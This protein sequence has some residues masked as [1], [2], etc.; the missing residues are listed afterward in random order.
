MGNSF[1]RRCRPWS[2]PYGASYRP[3]V[4][5]STVDSTPGSSILLGGTQTTLEYALW[6]PGVGGLYSRVVNSPGGNQTTLEYA[7]WC[8]GSGSTLLQG[9]QLS[10]EIPNDPGVLP[11]VP[12]KWVDST[13]G[14]LILLVENKRPWS[15]PCG[16]QEVGR[17]YSRVA[18]SPGK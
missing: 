1:W 2:S 11:M 9:R 15:T 3:T 7:L 4:P 14:S 5:C 17:L 18:N 6:S 16:A 13:P 10:W 8:P 12:R